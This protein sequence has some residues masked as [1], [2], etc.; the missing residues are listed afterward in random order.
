M[1]V[2]KA[3]LVIG[4][5]GGISTAL[6][7]FI[8]E[9]N[10]TAPFLISIPLAIL[11]GVL[12]Y[13]NIS[14]SEEY[15]NKARA[16]KKHSYCDYFW[17]MSF[18]IGEAM[19]IFTCWVIQ[20]MSWNMCVGVTLWAGIYGFSHGFSHDINLTRDLLTN[21]KVKKPEIYVEWLKLE[22]NNAQTSFQLYISLLG[23]VVT[24]GIVGYFL[25]QGSF[26]SPG[27]QS[28]LVITI[29]GILGM[30]FGI[31]GPIQYK[32]YLLR[33]KIRELASAS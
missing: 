8:E 19:G 33:K 25:Y 18:V 20:A 30:W 5:Y 9:K 23:L 28:T 15:E 16:R 3:S 22:H 21:A 29:W 6:F 7:S 32:M 14:L 2:S 31:L 12:L 4:L 17:T 11:A 26:W 27:M 24:G 13:I 10:F 1:M